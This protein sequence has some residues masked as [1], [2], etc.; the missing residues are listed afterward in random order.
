MFVLLHLKR[1]TVDKVH[2]TDDLTCAIPLIKSKKKKK[3]DLFG[4]ADKGHIIPPQ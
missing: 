1:Q 3:N 2:K 4:E